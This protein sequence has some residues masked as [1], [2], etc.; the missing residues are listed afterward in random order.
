LRFQADPRKRK[1]Q[2]N[3][4][5][6]GIKSPTPLKRAAGD[7][8]REQVPAHRRVGISPISQEKESRRKRERAGKSLTNA[9]HNDGLC[10]LISSAQT[11]SNRNDR[12][13]HLS[14][15]LE[16]DRK[17]NRRG[18]RRGGLPK[19]AIMNPFFN[20]FFLPKTQE[21]LVLEGATPASLEQ[22]E[23]PA[24]GEPGDWLGDK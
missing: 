10:R 18:N 3:S 5:Q 11:V 6:G 1:S 24:K 22:L 23:A 8:K 20:S 14:F 17:G 19:L 2:R 21:I 16:R 4:S 15:S 12:P 9:R 13:P 7:V